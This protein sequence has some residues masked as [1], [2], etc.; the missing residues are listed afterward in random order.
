MA[1]P[2]VLVVHK[3]KP[4]VAAVTHIME[5]GRPP[6]RPPSEP[7]RGAPGGCSSRGRPAEAGAAG[8]AELAI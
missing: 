1:F 6:A 7:R 3:P 2:S 5:P 4:L 8:S